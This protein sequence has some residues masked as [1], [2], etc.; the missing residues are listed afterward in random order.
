MNPI[1]AKRNQNEGLL[2]KADSEKAALLII[3]IDIN[4]SG[5]RVFRI[6][7]PGYDSPSHLESLSKADKA[8][9]ILPVFIVPLLM[10]ITDGPIPALALT[11]GIASVWNGLLNSKQRMIKEQALNWWRKEHGKEQ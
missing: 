9:I 7:L 5:G 4:N 8:F 3:D 6:A 11:F 1:E 2:R 10:S